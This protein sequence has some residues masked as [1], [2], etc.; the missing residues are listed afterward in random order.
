MNKLAFKWSIYQR[1]QIHKCIFSLI[2]LGLCESFL[3]LMI[4]LFFSISLKI[5]ENLIPKNSTADFVLYML[6]PFILGFD[7]KNFIWM[8][9]YFLKWILLV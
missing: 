8:F 1:Q 6:A 7:V 4:F 5:W 2:K 3:E 9:F